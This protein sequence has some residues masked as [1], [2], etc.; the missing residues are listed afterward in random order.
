MGLSDNENHSQPERAGKPCVHLLSDTVAGTNYHV[1]KYTMCAALVWRLVSEDAEPTLGNLFLLSC[2]QYLI[3]VVLDQDPTVCLR[4]RTSRLPNRRTA[5]STWKSVVTKLTRPAA[6]ETTSPSAETYPP[7]LIVDDDADIRETLNLVFEETGYPILEAS[8]GQE[9]LSIMRG[10]PER[11]IILLDNYMPVLDGEGVLRAIL[12]DRQLRRR[13]AIIFVSAMAR[14]S[15]RLRLQRLLQSLAIEAVTKP[16]NITDVEQAVER[17]RTRLL[18][19]SPP[20]R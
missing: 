7:L 15:R 12:Q 18:R 10:S 13:H 4:R 20:S 3:I 9:A 16:F 17:A 8:N 1:A 11:L 5:M 19:V 6:L 2:L 14:L